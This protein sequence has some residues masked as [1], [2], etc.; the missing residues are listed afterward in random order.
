[1]ND[2][3]ASAIHMLRDDARIW[4]GVVMQMRDVWTM[5]WEEFQEVFNEKYFSNTVRWAKV[6]EFA[7]LVHGQLCVIEY[8]QTF[9]RLARFVPELVPIDRARR[10]KFIRGLNNIVA[11]DVKI[12]MDLTRTIYAQ[13]VERTFIAE[14]AEEQINR[15]NAVKCESRRAA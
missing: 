10:D 5:T 1:M 13:L 12:T 15:E 7:S 11:R 6:E 8:A 2:K 4:W 3:V 9:E 14:G